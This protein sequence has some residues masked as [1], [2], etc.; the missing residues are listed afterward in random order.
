MPLIVTQTTDK[1]TSPLLHSVL[2]DG[3]STG[4]LKVFTGVFERPITDE[5]MPEKT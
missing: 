1:P 4:V 3:E 2:G 5:D